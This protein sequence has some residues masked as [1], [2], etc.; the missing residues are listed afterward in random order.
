MGT[1]VQL[2]RADGAGEKWI[3][4]VFVEHPDGGVQLLAE[5]RGS[6]DCARRIAR[7]SGRILRRKNGL[8]LFLAFLRANKCR[9]A[10]ND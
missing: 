8:Y 4:E 10:A 1:L 3:A 2:A 9:V 6:W 7:N 5:V